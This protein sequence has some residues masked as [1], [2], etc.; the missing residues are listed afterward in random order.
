M[1]RLL[2]YMGQ[3]VVGIGDIKL[4]CRKVC[5]MLKKIGFSFRLKPLLNAG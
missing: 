5:Q 3:E 1:Q 2:I 4:V